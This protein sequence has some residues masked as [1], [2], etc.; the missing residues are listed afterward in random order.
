[1]I[2]RKAHQYHG[3]IPVSATIGYHLIKL[4][5]KINVNSS[6]GYMGARRNCCR[7][8]KPDPYP[9]MW[10]GG[11]SAEVDGGGVWGGGIR[12]PSGGGVWGGGCALSPEKFWHF[13]LRNGA[14]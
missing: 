6:L 5:L 8:A 13:L 11:S 12:L 2:T 10:S 1:M 4:N 14:F 7:G 3:D 9:E